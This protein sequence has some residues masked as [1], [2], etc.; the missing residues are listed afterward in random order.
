MNKWARRLLYLIITFVWLSIMLF[1]VFA[2]RLATNGQMQ[3]GNTTIFMVQER[4]EAGVGFQTT[5]TVEREA[6]CT[7]TTIRYVLWEGEGDNN[8]SCSCSDGVEREA[9]RRSCVAP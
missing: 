9:H 1:P 6:T 7:L 4:R 2:V 5:R 3:V 8:R